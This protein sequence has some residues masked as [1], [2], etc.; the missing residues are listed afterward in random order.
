MKIIY[1]K[2]LNH[3]KEDLYLNL[4]N[5]EIDL[6]YDILNNLKN[7]NIIITEFNE[8]NIL[9]NIYPIEENKIIQNNNLNF[10]IDNILKIFIY[11]FYYEEYLSIYK[12]NY[13]NE[14]ESYFLINPKWLKDYKDFYNYNKLF[15]LL[16]NISNNN[17][18]KSINY[19]NLNE[20]NILNISN[21]LKNIFLEKRIDKINFGYKMPNLSYINNINFNES[22]FIIDEKIIDMI[23]NT[24][25]NLNEKIS[26]LSY[27]IKI[28]NKYVF[29]I[30]INS[31]SIGY[32]NDELL[33]IPKF[34]FFYNNYMILEREINLL[35]SNNIQDYIKYR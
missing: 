12:E 1:F 7:N 14:N 35:F 3:L 6:N 30:N 24:H 18:N 34:L 2:T 10:I 8:L 25:K 4:L 19:Q 27:K 9:Y 31:I 16:K 11:I 17:N 13:F 33:F 23:I 26:K 28:K 21:N 22:C 20:N 5:K 29:L 32:I 15:E